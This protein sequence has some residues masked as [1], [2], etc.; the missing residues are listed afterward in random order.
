MTESQSYKGGMRLDDT[1][2]ESNL[3]EYFVRTIAGRQCTAT[4]VL[5]KAVTNMG[6]V[7]PVGLIDVQ[8]MIAQ[9]DGYGQPTPHGIIHDVPYMRMQGGPAAVILDPKVGDIGIAVFAHRDISAV[10]ASK[11]PANPGSRRKH[12]WADAMYVGGVLNGAPEQYI[13]FTSDGEIELKPATKVTVLGKLD[14]Q[15]DVTVEGNIMSTKTITGSTDVVGGGKSLATHLHSGVTAGGSS[16]G[17]P[18]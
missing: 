8:P 18:V 2:S 4:L 12:N 9:L 14:V 17:P 16:S 3:L 5:V 13:R 1:T 7:S 10:K 11:A 15:G 6:E